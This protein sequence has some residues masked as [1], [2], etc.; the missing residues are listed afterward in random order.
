MIDSARYVEITG[1]VQA[2]SGP[3]LLVGVIL[4][5]AAADCSIILYDNTA[6]SGSVIVQLATLAKTC[7]QFTPCAPI[8]FGKGIYADITGSGATCYLAV[9]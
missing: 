1:D 6:A 7:A 3:G 5:S 4:V 2:V 8:A 9:I